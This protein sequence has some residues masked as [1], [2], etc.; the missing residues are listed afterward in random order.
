MGYNV[1]TLDNVPVNSGYYFLLLGKSEYTYGMSGTALYHKFD[2]IAQRIDKDSA[3]VKSY[4]PS[5]LAEE[6]LRAIH[7]KPWFREAYVTLLRMEPAL[8]IMKPHPAIFNFCDDELFVVASFRALDKI[9]ANDYDLIH[10][11]VS[12]ASNEDYTLLRKIKNE[13]EGVGLLRRVGDS[14]E[15]T[16][17]FNGLGVNLRRLFEDEHLSSEQ[18]TAHWGK[19]DLKNQQ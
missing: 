6:L 10:D 4:R 9:Y 14:L 1:S 8:V 15:L 13:T 11:I 7:R 18:V 5:S 12:L 17:N 16:P 2:E 3:I 19:Y